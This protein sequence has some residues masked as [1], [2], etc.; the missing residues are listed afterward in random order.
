MN[1]IFHYPLP[2]DQNAK[3]ASG[4]RPLRML[5]AFIDLG[6]TVHLVT[7][8]AKERRASIKVIKANIESG[9]K[10]DF[11]YSESSTMPTALTEKTHIPTHPLLDFLFIR[12]CHK[13][14]IPTSL[15]YRDVQWKFDIYGKG[16]SPAKIIIAKFFYRFDIFCYRHCLS[17]LYLPSVEMRDYIKEIKELPVRALQPGHEV[18]LA[19][20]DEDRRTQ[21]RKLNILYVGGLSA[22]YR[23]DV[24]VNAVERFS[25]VKLT[26]CTREKDW[27]DARDNF[28][29]ILPANIR[30]VHASGDQLSDLYAW[31]DVA[32]LYLAPHEYSKFAYPMKLFEYIGYCKPVLASE[33]TLYGSFVEKNQIGWCVDYNLEDISDFFSHIMNN[34]DDVSTKKNNVRTIQTKHT[35]LA[36]AQQ[37]AEDLS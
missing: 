35:W 13:E 32:S 6:Y 18:N 19:T 24:L 25:E 27:L 21:S 17:C 12:F 23:M 16:L 20:I 1:I 2:L 5:K 10:Y 22:L 30:I 8:Y 28:P 11:L 37:V 33:G 29:D 34:L 15:F 36:R 7:G 3:S 31:A 4:I 26:I 9:I 14:G